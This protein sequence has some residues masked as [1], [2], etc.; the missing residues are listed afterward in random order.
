VRAYFALID[1]DAIVET[2]LYDSMVSKVNDQWLL[3]AHHFI[4][5]VLPQGANR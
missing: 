5:D 4:A 3:A 2:G 1:G